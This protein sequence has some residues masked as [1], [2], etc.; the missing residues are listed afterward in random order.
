MSPTKEKN[1]A[2]LKLLCLKNLVILLI[3]RELINLKYKYLF[4]QIIITNLF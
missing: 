3:H 4:V 2:I 1:K